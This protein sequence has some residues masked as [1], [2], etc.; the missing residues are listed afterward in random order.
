MSVNAL[1]VHLIVLMWVKVL[2]QCTR[3]RSWEM[4]HRRL[5]WRQYATLV[6]G[7]RCPVNLVFSFSVF[8]EYTDNY[9][10]VYSALTK[11][12]SK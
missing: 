12:S 6:I 3:H 4:E 10:L 7:E 5:F 8:K 1:L 2:A 9:R 11:Q